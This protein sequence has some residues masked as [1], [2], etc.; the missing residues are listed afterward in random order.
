MKRHWK[1]AVIIALVYVV[2]V[3]SGW[4]NGHGDG[5]EAGYNEG[6]GWGRSSG[7]SEGMKRQ[8][9]WDSETCPQLEQSP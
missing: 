5:L 2:G 6:Y 1:N 3:A 4:V 9:K 7:I 8:R